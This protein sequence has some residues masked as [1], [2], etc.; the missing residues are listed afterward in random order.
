MRYITLEEHF[1]S[2]AFLAGPGREFME[3]FRN[4]GARGA[5]IVERLQDVGGTRIAEM[6]AAGIG[7]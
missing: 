6:D 2:P 1:A 7:P 3:R 5:R 4:S